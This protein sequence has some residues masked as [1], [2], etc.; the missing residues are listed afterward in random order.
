MGPELSIGW[1]SWP[2]DPGTSLRSQHGG[3]PISVLRGQKLQ[4]A[5]WP[6][7]CGGKGE[8]GVGCGSEETCGKVSASWLLSGWE[9]ALDPGGGGTKSMGQW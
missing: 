5:F 4:I 2:Q 1:D 7:G 9:G 6:H 3:P 8:R